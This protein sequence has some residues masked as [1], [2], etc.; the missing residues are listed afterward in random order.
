MTFRTTGR[1]P[2]NTRTRGKHVERRVVLIAVL[3][4]LFVG[5][6]ARVGMAFLGQHG[7][8]DVS[9]DVICDGHGAVVRQVSTNNYSSVGF[10]GSTACQDG[11]NQ[12]FENGV[13][14]SE[15]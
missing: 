7:T 10:T 1:R 12:T 5:A 2:M 4:V 13:L 11:T 6:F 15:E 3:T 14:A 9:T 8:R